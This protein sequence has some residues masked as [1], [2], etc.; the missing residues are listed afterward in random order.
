LIIDLFFFSSFQKNFTLKL[1]NF[2]LFLTLVKSE[3]QPQVDDDVDPLDAYMQGIQEEVKKMRSKTVKSDE[4]DNKVTVVVG[5]AKKAGQQKKGELIEQNQDA[6]EYSSEDEGNKDDDLANA[7]DNLQNKA[8]QKK[9]NTITKD[10]IT[11]HSFRKNFYI[12]VPELAKMSN[13]EVETFRAEMEGIK[14]KGKGCPKPIK[15]WAQCGVSKKVLDVLK[16]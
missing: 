1:I 7:M 16:K 3:P 12:E 6:L 15:T 11:Y 14:A 2:I 13:E 9:L 4:K 8:K 10:D 5:I